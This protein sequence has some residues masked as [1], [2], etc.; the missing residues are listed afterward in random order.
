MYRYCYVSILILRYSNI[1]GQRYVAS[2]HYFG[3]KGRNELIQLRC[4][5]IQLHLGIVNRACSALDSHGFYE[6]PFGW[7]ADGVAT[8][9]RLS[10]WCNIASLIAVDIASLLRLM[11]VPLHCSS[12]FFMC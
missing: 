4:L 8:L 10:L 3:T 1:C 7:D 6:L 9:L 11:H 12:V 5:E 2:V